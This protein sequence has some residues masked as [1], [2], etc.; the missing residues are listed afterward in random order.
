MEKEARKETMKKGDKC[1]NEM[2]QQWDGK[3]ERKGQKG[4]KKMWEKRGAVWF[5]SHLSHSLDSQE[6]GR[7]PVRQSPRRS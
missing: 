6:R 7:R 4:G 1:T 2:K 5:I 3:T